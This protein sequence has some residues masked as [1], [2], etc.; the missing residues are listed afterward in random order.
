[1]KCDKYISFNDKTGLFSVNIEIT[2]L[3]CGSAVDFLQN[4]VAELKNLEYSI[5]EKK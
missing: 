3:T 2:G 1:M 5:S 4:T